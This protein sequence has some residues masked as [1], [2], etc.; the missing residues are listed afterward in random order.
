MKR[1]VVYLLSLVISSCAFAA[2]SF[3]LA[4]PN[5]LLPLPSNEI[6]LGQ[7]VSIVISSDTNEPWQG[8]IFV[9]GQD[10]FVSRIV[11]RGSN[12]VLRHYPASCFSAAGPHARAMLWKDSYL[13][14]FDFYTEAFDPNAGDWFV[15]DYQALRPGT[16]TL[17]FYDYTT[18]DPNSWYVPAQTLAVENTPSRDFTGDDLVNLEDFAHFASY[19]LEE[20]CAAPDWCAQ[21][22]LDW[23]GLVGL[24]DLTLFSE[25]WLRGMPGWQ[26]APAPAVIDPNLFYAITDS[27]DAN[28]ITLTVG[29]SVRLY[30]QKT[31]LEQEVR[32]I[33]LEA[34]ISD[35]ELGWI[36]NTE[37]DPN[38]PESST[39]EL[40]VEPRYTFF[41]YWG[42]GE[43]Q[44][45]GIVFFATGLG[46][47]LSDGPVAS[48][49]YTAS[50]PGDVILDLIDYGQ[51][52]S[53][54]HRMVIH[55]VAPM[56]ANAP[57]TQSFQTM[58]FAV[59]EAE[60]LSSAESAETAAESQIV[61]EEAVEF[62]ERIWEE[63]PQIREQISEEQW[64]D[65]IEKVRNSSV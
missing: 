4:D 45:E 37:Y 53:A 40:L 23:D 46:Q 16:C 27:E 32:L 58:S 30:I 62:L 15:V 29:E 13:Q 49:V 47:N 56:Q 48:F 28:E 42:P 51:I 18:G 5:T 39:A 14:G 52:P 35:T 24:A 41:D 11:G 21:T 36:D 44:P 50:E 2:V 38:N 59:P 61:T 57:D 19:W 64:N 55:Q 60:N 25:H 10:R 7:P 31:T 33:Y 43:T 63:D 9:R 26:P 54:R 20:G 6:L 65:F 8:G 3:R 34:T 17:E 22:D 12:P 1:G